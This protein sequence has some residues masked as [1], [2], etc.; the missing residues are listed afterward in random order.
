MVPCGLRAVL[1]AM[2]AVGTLVVLLVLLAPPRGRGTPYQDYTP[3]GRIRMAR[4]RERGPSYVKPG[5]VGVSVVRYGIQ[6][7]ADSV[8]VITAT[9]ANS[10]AVAL[11][12]IHMRIAYLKTGEEE[13]ADDMYLRAD[14]DGLWP[15]EEMEFSF[16]PV[17]AGFDTCRIT[18]VSAKSL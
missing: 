14:G 13:R 16:P 1:L 10:T 12:T 15:G 9:I 3:R 11:H 5:P 7:R 2:A 4:G 18:A 6:A 8:R 17:A